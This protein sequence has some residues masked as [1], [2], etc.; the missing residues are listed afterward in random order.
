MM[1][2]ART[3]KLLVLVAVCIHG[4][5]LGD[6]D[7]RVDLKNVS[8]EAKTDWPVILRVYTMLGRNLD[9]T[10]IRRDGFHV[11][12]PSGAEEARARARSLS[13][14]AVK[15]IRGQLQRLVELAGQ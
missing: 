15:G 8:G 1:S 12:D 5:A 7:V 13:L 3:L 14:P 10:T 9:P 4:V 6:Y 2:M 11:Y